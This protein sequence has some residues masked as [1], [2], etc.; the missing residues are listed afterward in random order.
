MKN[1]N[2]YEPMRHGLGATWR[3][4]ALTAAL[5]VVGPGLACGGDSEESDPVRRACTGAANHLVDCGLLSPGP[6]DCTSQDPASLGISPG[7]AD[8]A[9][10]L[11][12]C[13]ERAECGALEDLLCAEVVGSTSIPTTI[14]SC[15]FG[16]IE[17]FGFQCVEAGAGATSVP[18]LAICDGESD[19]NDGSDEIGCQL[20]ACGDGQSVATR[21]VCDGYLDCDNG[22]DEESCLLFVCNDGSELPEPFRCDGGADCLDGSDEAGCP[23]RA[24]STCGR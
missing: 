11:L 10:C 8:E 3:S 21:A 22:Q 6:V 1:Q 14:L 20:F 13:F 16:C 12:T 15:I 9:A 17:Q 24:T 7:S 4:W 23:E 18:S 5:L 19:C 2:L